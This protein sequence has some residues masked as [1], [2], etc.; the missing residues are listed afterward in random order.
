MGEE[1]SSKGNVGNGRNVENGRSDAFGVLALI[2]FWWS[3]TVVK[4]MLEWTLG[5]LRR[6]RLN[7]VLWSGTEV[8]ETL[9]LGRITS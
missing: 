5:R 8:K 7:H 4:A 2:I 1:Y 3:G 6:P 9:T